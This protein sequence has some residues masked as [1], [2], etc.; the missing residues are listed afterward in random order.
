MKKAL[1]VILTSAIILSLFAFLPQTSLAAA[2]S[3]KCGDN[4]TWSYNTSTKTLTIS[5][6]GAMTNYSILY[7]DTAG[8][9]IT[10]A[11]W[12]NYYN[13]IKTVVISSGVTSIGSSAFRGCSSLTSIAIPNSVTS[14][15]SS[16]FYGCSS[17]KYNTYSNAKYLGNGANPYFALIEATSTDITYCTINNNTKVIACYAFEYCSSLTSVT[18]GNGVTSI[19]RGAFY[20][21]RSL[22]SVTIPDGVK[23][24][25]SSAFSDCSSLTSVTIPDS[26]TSIGDNAFDGCSS[27]TSIT[28]P[29]SVTSIGNYAFY[30]CTSLSSVTIG[31]GVTSIERAAFSDCSSLTSVTIPD[32]VTSIG[33]SAFYHCTSLTSVTI[34]DS[35]TSIGGSAF[36]DC[37]SLTSINI[38]DSVTSIGG[39]AF[40]GCSSLKSITVDTGNPVYHSDGNCLIETETKTL[41]S[42]CKNSIIPADGSV[43]SIGYSAF[44]DCSKL[45]SVTIPDSVTSIGNHAFYH[46][47][48]LTSVTIPDSVTSIGEMAFCGCSK[49]KQIAIPDS[50]T[51]IGRGAFW[52]CPI[53]EL[54]IG[55]SVKSIG[56]E[57]FRACTAL[58]SITIPVSVTSIGAS[59][60]YACSA[61]K[62]VYYLGSKE[63]KNNLSIEKDNSPL[64]NAE[65]HYHTAHEWDNGVITVEPTCSGTG[66]KTLTCTVCGATSSVT[67]PASHKPE[68]T[69]VPPT[70]TEGGMYFVKCS[71]CGEFLDTGTLPAAGHTVVEVAAKEPTCTEEGSTAGSYCS[72]C[73]V[74]LSD[75]EKIPALGHN[76]V[77][78][79]IAPTC[80]SSGMYSEKCT[81]CGKIFDAGT[82]PTADHTVVTDKAVAPT[83]TE[84]GLT[85][86]SHCSVCGEVIKAQESIPAKGHTGSETRVE[87]TCTEDG[88]STVTCTVCGTTLS[89]ASIPALGHDFE[90]EFTVDVEPTTTT[91]GSKSRHCTR[92]SEV[93]DVT[94]IPPIKPQYDVGDANCDGSLNMKDVLFLRKVLA[95]ADELTAEQLRYADL[96]GNGDINMKDV[97]KLRKIVAG[98][99]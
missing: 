90:E 1:S 59:A 3:G 21:C 43:T 29:D 12:R 67:L 47:T 4:L 92:C 31:N 36:S 69:E 82:I 68:R 30:N 22:T 81:R 91:P 2:T 10:A 86:G 20:D 71:V 8:T 38:P 83:C 72:V 75:Y 15:G 93:T 53:T 23:S 66:E 77:R 35:V 34:P 50:V 97:L 28:I 94:E 32:S 33:S 41:I 85:E 64:I 65:W 40:S 14:I 13:S 79:E 52:G 39:S 58:K 16:A 11:P 48:S 25:G 99:E 6:T 49:V 60:F 17:L 44:Y 98:A 76:I 61:L 70:C 96:D 63:Q 89:K 54:T 26:V 19:G 51:E 73:G 78:T 57:A 27:L 87:P 9:W 42:G 74:M 88:D 55:K 18:I 95:G 84:A 7:N 45:T 37:S 80:K 24:I 5:G 56:A 46:C 62:D